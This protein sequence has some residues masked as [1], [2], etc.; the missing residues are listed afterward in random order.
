MRF[1]QSK[2][3]NTKM[4]QKQTENNENYGSRNTPAELLENYER[5]AQETRNRIPQDHLLLGNII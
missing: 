5:G 1:E 3:R 4:Q 2:F